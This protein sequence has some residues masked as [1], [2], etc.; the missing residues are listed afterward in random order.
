MGAHFSFGGISGSF[1]RLVLGF[2]RPKP[3]FSAVDRLAY[4]DLWAYFTYPI[5]SINKP[6]RLQL[7]PFHLQHQEVTF[8]LLQTIKFLINSSFSSLQAGID[9]LAAMGAA[10]GLDLELIERFLLRDWSLLVD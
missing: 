3:G 6:L 4:F 9:A 1:G 7:T 2:E 10:R 5:L 8:P